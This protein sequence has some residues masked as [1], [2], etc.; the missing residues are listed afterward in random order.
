MIRSL[1]SGVAGLRTHQ[2]KM[3]V[4]GN[5]I[6][7]VNT[8][9]FK[10][11]RVTFADT[12]Y[13]N[14]NGASAGSA[15]VQGGTN[16]TQIGY[17]SSVA[18]IDVMNTV[19]GS[20]STDRALDVY[21]GGDG[22]LIC[23]DVSG[24]TSYTRLGNL[25]FDS[26]G[27]LVDG[28]GKLVQGAKQDA[29]GN[30]IINPDGTIGDID[31][32]H[33]D[34]AILDKL[35]G[36]S[37][38]STGRIVG[39]LPGDKIIVPAVTGPKYV[40]MDTLTI[41]S[42][43]NFSGNVTLKVGSLPT[44]ADFNAPPTDT[45]KVLN[46]SYGDVGLPRADGTTISYTMAFD[47]KTL[48]LN[49]TDNINSKNSVTYEGV[50]KD[51]GTVVLKSKSTSKTAMTLKLDTPVSKAP[52]GMAPATPVDVDHMFKE[53][54]YEVETRDDGG[55]VVKLPK[56]NQ[57]NRVYDNTGALVITGT[58]FPGLD[59]IGIDLIAGQ[60][61]TPF[62]GHI[63]VAKPD[64]EMMFTIGSLAIAKFGN[65]NGMKETGSGYFSESANSGS[66]TIVSP[67]INGTGTVA[68]GYL[69]LSNVDVSNEF[70]NMITTQRGFQA[71]SRIIT[72]SD[73]MLEELVNL[74]R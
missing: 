9:G 4:I 16:P 21:I 20:S 35:T 15:Q 71:N 53:V 49:V 23:R 12:Y 63:G 32:I 57:D 48:T 30:P 36:I 45:L 2:T 11:S 18:T 68:A 43:S 6:A 1:S 50:V 29:D 74:K 17:G 59:G 10:A 58:S 66:P 14:I 13:Q 55:N 67:G 51:D 65:P 7:N 31:T 44:V 47:G 64:D 62:Y 34:P 73:T 28:N 72:V 37:I 3:D 19:S 42:D 26:A 24:N 41:P 56:D 39:V 60:D 38:S 33:C 61:I 5:N 69:E 25:G 22:F 52:F 46:S 8:Y 27:N 54:R 40:N 70:T